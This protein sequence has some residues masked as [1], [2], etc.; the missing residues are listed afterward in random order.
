MDVM[1]L[2]VARLTCLL[3]QV[4]LPVPG[5]PMTICSECWV[6]RSLSVVNGVPPVVLVIG[7]CDGPA[8]F[9]S[10]PRRGGDRAI[11][12]LT[13]ACPRRPSKISFITRGGFTGVAGRVILAKVFQVIF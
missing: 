8:R 9:C 4:V 11:F 7:F 1:S 2:S 3:N 12:V 10:G 6:S 5:G 13:R